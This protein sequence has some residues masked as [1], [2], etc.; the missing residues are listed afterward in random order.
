[1]LTN[2]NG[3]QRL[4][5]GAITNSAGGRGPSSS[6]PLLRHWIAMIGCV[7]ATIGLAL[8][9][10]RLFALIAF[11]VASLLFSST[12]FV[13]NMACDARYLYLITVATPFLLTCVAALFFTA[14]KGRL[15]DLTGAEG[16]Y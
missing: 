13:F 10:A 16:L 14:S 6:K 1:M 15:V 3:V 2:E 5:D 7:V 8:N 11:G 9:P 12:F 4:A